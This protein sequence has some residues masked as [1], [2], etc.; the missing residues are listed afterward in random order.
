MQRRQCVTRWQP[1]PSAAP[2]FMIAPLLFVM[3]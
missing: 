2:L 3:V 1:V